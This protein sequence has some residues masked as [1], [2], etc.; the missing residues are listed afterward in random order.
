MLLICLGD[1]NDTTHPGRAEEDPELLLFVVVVMICL[2][3]MLVG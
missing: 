2:P 1:A 3:K